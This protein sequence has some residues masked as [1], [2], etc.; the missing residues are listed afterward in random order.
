MSFLSWLSRLFGSSPK[1]EPLPRIHGKGRYLVEVT[2]CD[3][4]QP[5]LEKLCAGINM[6]ETFLD[7]DADL[8]E[9]PYDPANRHPVNV[10]I[11]GKPVG[12]LSERES[13]PAPPTPPASTC[14]IDLAGT[15]VEGMVGGYQKFRRA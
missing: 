1:T 4:F 12:H 8:I 9:L 2:D 5:A 3:L 13:T 14:P 11:R 6:E 10:L 15:T 7:T